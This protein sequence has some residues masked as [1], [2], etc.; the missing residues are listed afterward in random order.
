MSLV[1]FVIPD[2]WK[3]IARIVFD[4]DK[5]MIYIYVLHICNQVHTYVIHTIVIYLFAYL[6]RYSRISTKLNKK[7][8]T[9][10]VVVVKGVP[11]LFKV[12]GTA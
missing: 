1:Y 6:I 7:S 5:D 12:I 10:Y 8:E 3:W 11:Y 4:L 2:P 9:K